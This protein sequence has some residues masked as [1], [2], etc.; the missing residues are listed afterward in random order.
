MGFSASFASACFPLLSGCLASPGGLS[1]GACAVGSRASRASPWAS[2][3]SHVLCP[4]CSDA[5]RSRCQGLHVLN[6]ATK[7]HFF[8][9]PLPPPSRSPLR[10]LCTCPCSSPRRRVV[11]PGGRA[12]L[13][14]WAV[15]HAFPCP[16]NKPGAWRLFLPLGLAPAHAA[17]TLFHA[18]FHAFPTYEVI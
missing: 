7:R 10:A 14:Y 3:R 16:G 1:G 8:A 5:T 6:S 15:I 11:I 17:I 12:P 9:E 18:L 2:L 4:I 13:A